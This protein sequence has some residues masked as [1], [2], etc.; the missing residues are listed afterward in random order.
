[1]EQRT[2][3]RKTKINGSWLWRVSIVTRNTWQKGDQIDKANSSGF[4][5]EVFISSFKTKLKVEMALTMRA[6]RLASVGH[7]LEAQASNWCLADHDQVEDKTKFWAGITMSVLWA[8][9]KVSSTP[10]C[11][12]Q[13]THLIT[14]GGTPHLYN[15]GSSMLVN[16]LHPGENNM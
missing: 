14:T 2:T 10:I 6:L 1:M 13:W 11:M 16:S 5:T 12:V 9:I 3:A 7:H 15:R 8:I 4:P